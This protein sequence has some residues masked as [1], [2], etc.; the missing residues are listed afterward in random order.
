MKKLQKKRVLLSAGILCILA[1]AVGATIAY[2]H[3]R[4]IIGN[5]F[6]PSVYKTTTTEQFDSPDNWMTCDE[7]AKTVPRGAPFLG[8][9]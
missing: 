1:L 8:A 4:S 2:N 6:V 7:T 5:N 3:D 9:E